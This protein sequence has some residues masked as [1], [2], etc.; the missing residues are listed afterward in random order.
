[1]TTPKKPS[2]TPARK[3]WLASLKPGSEALLWQRI[4]GWCR[5]RIVELQG[6][7]PHRLWLQLPSGLYN[8]MGV[9]PDGSG[10]AT[11]GGRLARVIFPAT[12][13]TAQ[14]GAAL[15][16][17][18]LTL[19]RVNWFRVSDSAVERIADIVRIDT[20]TGAKP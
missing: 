11:E 4:G 5:V 18:R 19:G 1:M 8:D 17:A 10:L 16:T 7:K 9:V 15:D 20:A 3:A 12:D 6:C 14:R 2:L 13:P